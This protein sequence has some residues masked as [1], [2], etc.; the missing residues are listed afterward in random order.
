MPFKEAAAARC[1]RLDAVAAS[2]GAVNTVLLERD[3]WSGYNTDG[4]ALLE[5]ARRHVD[6]RE[7]V[8]AIVG[9]GGTARTAASVLRD[10]GARVTL[11]NRD[12]ARARRVAA[13]L[14]VRSGPL[15]DLSRDR[16]D[17]L[18]QATPLGKEGERLLAA[19]EVRGD[20]VLDAVYGAV[21]TPLI[22]DARARGIPA[23]D[24]IELLVAQ[25]VLQ[26][27][28]MTGTRPDASVMHDAARK[29]L[30]RRLR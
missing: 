18:V 24:G 5:L 11:Y 1:V 25:A 6:P 8:A 12:L 4:P 10:A 29:W 22:A 28:R 19:D 26:F 2:A 3:G 23:A 30:G 27:E 20:W 15:E 17:L 21:Q 14:G 7:S 13:A 9:A 16:W